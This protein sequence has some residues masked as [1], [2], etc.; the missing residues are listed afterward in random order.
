MATRINHLSDFTLYETFT[1]FDKQVAVPEHFRI[2]Y[3]TE[4]GFPRCFVAERNGSEFR[5]CDLS[6][7]GNTL[8]VYFTLSRQYIGTGP[9]KKIITEIFEDSQFP[10]GERRVS[11]PAD[12]SIVLWS[13]KSD[14]S[15]DTSDESV[16][17]DLLY[18]YSAYE[19]AKKYGYEGTE[20]EY[21]MAPLLAINE[22]PNY[23]KKD[24]SNV[25]ID[26]FQ[27][28]G[29][30]IMHLN[31]S[32][33]DSDDL[34]VPGVYV[35]PI[36]SIDVD[37]VGFAETIDLLG[38]SIIMTVGQTGTNVKYQYIFCQEETGSY[39]YYR[40][41]DPISLGGATFYP[42]LPDIATSNKA[43]L[44]KSGGDIT[45]GGDGT[46]SVNKT[47]TIKFNN[48]SD[49]INIDN[50]PQSDYGTISIWFNQAEADGNPPGQEGVIYQ[51]KYRSELGESS[52]TYVDCLTQLYV[53]S[54]GIKHRTIINYNDSSKFD[55][56]AWS[57]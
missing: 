50:Y 46:V 44:V 26:S 53:G 43:G 47:D 42:V 35:A 34:K 23:A 17:Q 25:T 27:Q 41:L 40:M 3:F 5:N 11:T 54:G 22:L 39:F 29:I 18:G 10:D 31:I 19:L 20:Q 9:V 7:D 37:T 15:V 28:K 36:S 12:T 55:G 2:T 48:S 52:S 45:V 32:D 8:H 56:V 24:L 14:D 57:E 16:L 38:N 13:G 30:P 1:R 4:T 6:T 49:A 33:I 21:A 51:T